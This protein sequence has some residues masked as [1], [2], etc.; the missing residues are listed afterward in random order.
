[1]GN[2]KDNNGLVSSRFLLKKFDY[3]NINTATLKYWRD[4]NKVAYEK[5][6]GRFFYRYNSLIQH[7]LNCF[8]KKID[9]KNL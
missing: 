7:M 9:E 8:G 3:L 2:W 5:L 6:K 4:S 1:M